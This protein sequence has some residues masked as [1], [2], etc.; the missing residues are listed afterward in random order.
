[1]TDDFPEETS[2][3]LVDKNSGGVVGAAGPLVDVGTLHTW[4]LIVDPTGC[5]NF[6]IFDSSGDGICCDWGIGFYNVYWNGDRVGFGGFFIA[7]GFVSNIGL[8][9]PIA[10]D[11]LEHT[12]ACCNNTQPGGAC[13]DN[14]PQ[15][16]C[17]DDDQHQ[18]Y[19]DTPCTAI[20]CDEHVGACCDNTQP[21][22]ACTDDV[23]QS[24]CPDDDQHQWYKRTS[25]S[26]VTCDEHVG[27]CCD[28]TQPG[29][30]CTDDVPE[31]QCPV[32][33]Q[34]QWYKRTPC[35]CPCGCT[36]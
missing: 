10:P 5:Y 33:D 8:C 36:V 32:D 15:S 20:T 24:Q 12:G 11:C 19:K 2:W 26:A 30:V 27:A 14:I 6:T 3:E 34:H 21:G 4:D 22:G 7:A 16:Q 13:T 25:C 31:S 17:P 35:A 18:W 28:N 9:G 23:A 1:M 29:G